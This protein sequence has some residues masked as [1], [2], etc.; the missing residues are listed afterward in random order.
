MVMVFDADYSWSCGL[1]KKQVRRANPQLIKSKDHA[2]F[3]NAKK[4]KPKQI[5]NQVFEGM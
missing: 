3:T 2:E 1:V 5:N 4:P